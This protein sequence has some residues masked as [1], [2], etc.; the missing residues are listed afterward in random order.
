MTIVERV[1]EICSQRKIPISNLEADCGFGNGY[2]GQ[3]K[4]GTIPADRLLIISR[5]LGVSI[6]YLIT[7][8]NEMPAD[9]ADSGLSDLQ[10][11]AVDI[12]LRLGPEELRRFVKILRAYWEDEA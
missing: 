10:K 9:H 4:K 12:V 2:I 6:I 11:E 5:Y 3:L 8:E 7:G 1:R